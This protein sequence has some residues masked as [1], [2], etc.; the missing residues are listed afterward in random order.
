MYEDHKLRRTSCNL[1]GKNW[2]EGL[3]PSCL[4]R[5]AEKNSRENS[6][7]RH[8]TF[9][10]KCSWLSTTLVFVVG[11][12]FVRS[13]GIIGPKSEETDLVNILK[14]NHVGLQSF[15]QHHNF[16]SNFYGCTNTK[17]Y[18]KWLYFNDEKSGEKKSFK[19]DKKIFR[20]SPVLIFDILLRLLFLFPAKLNYLF[21]YKRKCRRG[22]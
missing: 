6:A 5:G 22:H 18:N 12:S 2:Y 8:R 15:I 13:K 14:R 17:K 11:I 9:R 16:E 10:C 3:V 19:A 20:N 21:I 1:Q 7:R 4:E